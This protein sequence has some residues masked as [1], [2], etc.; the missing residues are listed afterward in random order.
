M[1]MENYNTNAMIH[2][3][4]AQWRADTPGCARVAHLNNAGSSLPPAPVTQAAID[5]LSQEALLG[6]Y[7][8]AARQADAIAGFYSAVARLIGARPHQI[9]FA[10]SATD[11]Y[12]RALSAILL[13]AGDVIVTTPDDYVS[14]QIAFLQCRQKGVKIVRAKTL[15]EGGVDPEDVRRLIREER[16][17]LVAVTHVPT[18]SGLVQPIAEIGAHCRAAG[19]LYLVDACQSAGQL[20]LD[21]EAIGC[22]FLSAT[23]R[24]FLRGPRGAGFLYVSDRVLETALAP[25]FLDLHSAQWTAPDIF[26][27]APDAR[28]FELWERN[29]ALVLAARA[30]AEYALGVGIPVIADHVRSLADYARQALATLPGAQV[31]DRGGELCG[32]VTA[33]FPNANPD[34][35]L[36]ALRLQ[37]I[38]T[39]VSTA[40]SARIDFAEKGV[41]WALRV[42]PHYYNTAEEIDAL[43]AALKRI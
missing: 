12:N 31:L 18:N 23:F 38:H 41:A 5:Y 24:K 19:V 13:R 2:P 29:Y 21:V 37:G 16:P 22:D 28:R 43:I 27:P 10:G 1:R 33:H 25:G 8:L 42:S 9:A 7:E 6:G 4:Q 3:L 40:G 39:S 26:E 14:N 17:A 32:I 11:A 15:P 30:A 36:E 20:P 35:L 34:A